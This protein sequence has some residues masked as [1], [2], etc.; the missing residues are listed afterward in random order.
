MAS[1]FAYP[2]DEKGASATWSLV[3]GTADSL[4]P[5]TN[6]NNVRPDAVSKLTGTSGTYRATITSTAVQAIVLVNHN[7]HG[8]TLTVTNNGGMASQNLVVPAARE[9]GLP[10][11]AWVDLRAV[12]TAATQWN[13][14]IPTNG[15]NVAV[16][17]I[18]LIGTARTLQATWN[19]K[20]KETIPFILHRTDYHVPLGYRMGTAY[21]EVTPS[22]AR[23]SERA[24][25][26]SLRRASVGPQQP[27]WLQLDETGTESI[28]GWFPS[29][30]WDYTRESPRITTWSDTIEEFCA[31]VAL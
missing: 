24:A 25:F 11:T 12:T 20:V 2:S 3:A 28:Y 6:L 13:I 8:L 16:G 17:N 31:G 4:F 10:S 22:F 14:A 7:L 9:D 30:S 15:A 5:L 29:D 21:R 23:E 19:V 1:L 27:F 18:L 26:I